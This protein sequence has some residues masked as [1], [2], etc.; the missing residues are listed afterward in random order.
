MAIFGFQKYYKAI[1]RSAAVINLDPAVSEV[2]YEASIDIREL[3]DLQDVMRYNNLGPNG[4]IL[5]C[6][7]YLETHFDWFLDKLDALTRSDPEATSSSQT[8]IDYI[9]LDLPGQIELSTDHQ[10]LKN[11]LHRLEKLDWRVQCCFSIRNKLFVAL[12][13]CAAN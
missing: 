4:S 10:S 3:I 6:L 2:P 13:W 5:F 11:V 1:G 9:V 12:L 8:A 7:E